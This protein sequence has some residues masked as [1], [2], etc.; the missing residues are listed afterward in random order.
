MLIDLFLK[1]LDYIAIFLYN[2]KILNY[3]VLI[4]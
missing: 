3:F 2:Y 1:Y 4:I